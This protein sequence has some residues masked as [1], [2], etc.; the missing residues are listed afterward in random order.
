MTYK[1]ITG[2]VFQPDCENSLVVIPHIVNNIGNWGSGFVVGVTQNVGP[3]P[4]NMYKKWFKGQ[5]YSEE[6]CYET[7]QFALGEVQFV[8]IRPLLTIANMVGQSGTINKPD[9]ISR[10]PIRYVA[11]SKAMIYVKDHIDSMICM[12]VA[13]DKPEIHCPKF[14]SERAGGDWKVIEQMILEIWVDQG[15]PVTVYEFKP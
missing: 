3:K 9:D 14:G 12:G 13:G 2:N 15:Y 1:I 10:P 5:L 6:G 7:G 11:L 4:E 8:N